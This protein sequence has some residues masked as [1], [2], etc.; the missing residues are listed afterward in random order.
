MKNKS[1]FAAILLAIVSAA[2]IAMALLSIGP[3]RTGEA[4]AMTFLA[5]AAAG[6]IAALL[7]AVLAAMAFLRSR[8]PA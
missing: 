5:W 2:S 1:S 3:V 4:S 6:I 8:K 7:C